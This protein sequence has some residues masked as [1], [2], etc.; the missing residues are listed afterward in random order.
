MQHVRGIRQ[1]G[2]MFAQS[3]LVD[4]GID[5]KVFGRAM[6]D[7]GVG[8]VEVPGDESRVRVDGGLG[9]FDFVAFRG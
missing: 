1:K 7:G 6:F 2:P 9:G 8:G 4:A 3:Q 5:V